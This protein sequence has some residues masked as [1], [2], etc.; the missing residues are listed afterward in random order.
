LFNLFQPPRNQARHWPRNRLVVHTL[1]GAKFAFIRPERQLIVEL[2][3]V[4]IQAIS[5]QR[6][7][8][9]SISL[10]G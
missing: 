2:E 9:L 10:F 1:V 5:V 7:H 3:I 8:W 4:F 6:K